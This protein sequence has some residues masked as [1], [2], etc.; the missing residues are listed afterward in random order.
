M[1]K[2]VNE[3]RYPSAWHASFADVTSNSARLILSFLQNFVRLDSMLEL[4]C[5][6]AHWSAN[7]LSLG[8]QTVCAVDGPWNNKERLNVASSQYIEAEI[9][10][11]FNVPGKFDMAICLEVAEHV[12]MNFATKTVSILSEASDVVLFGAAIPYQGGF[13][14]INEQWP[15]WWNEKFLLAG[16][17]PYDV[18]RPKFWNHPDIHYW[19]K[20]NTILYI[21]EGAKNID[22]EKLSSLKD[23][24]N[25]EYVMDIVHPEKFL[26][27]AS[28]SEVSILRFLK[29][30]PKH[31]KKR[32]LW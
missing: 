19:Y 1:S 12:D 3:A 18:I 9:N 2:A 14:H 32:I 25:G 29:K 17:R 7:A 24:G 26:S 11:N 5:G 28:Y 4:G 23:W 30:L 21:R 10:R 8:T 27:V 6:E 31:L 22:L 15:S 20:Q 13:G 16:F